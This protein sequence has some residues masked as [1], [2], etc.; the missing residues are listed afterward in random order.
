[1]IAVRALAIAVS[2]LAV[3]AGPAVGSPRDGA[4]AGRIAAKDARLTV[5]VEAAR[6]DRVLAEIARVT[7]LRIS[8]PPEML[9]AM[10]VTADFADVEIDTALARLMGNC[11]RV[12]VFEEASGA[13]RQANPVLREVRLFPAPAARALPLRTTTHPSTDAML[14]LERLGD[15]DAAVRAAVLESLG[16]PGQ[17]AL[18]ERMLA[19]GLGHHDPR[20]RL[21]TLTSGL[22]IPRDALVDHALN[23]V[24]PA[25]RAEALTQ[26]P[27]N[28]VRAGA[29]AQAALADQDEHVRHAAR[30]L[31]A[32]RPAHHTGRQTSRAGAR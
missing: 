26:L 3:L 28:D 8:A 19:T 25:V 30:D 20:T 10:L 21:A 24:S 9:E 16:R 15:P 13:G 2:A 31:L 23:D 11:D 12:L 18:V 29:V 27:P 17:E 5:K 32:G 7:D 22:S 1:M 14:L 6:A 4:V